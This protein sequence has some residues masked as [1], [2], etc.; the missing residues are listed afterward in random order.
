MHTW[1]NV[2]ILVGWIITPIENITINE[3]DDEDIIKQARKTKKESAY[4]L[5]SLDAYHHS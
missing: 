5:L 3:L 1:S 2:F 4:L